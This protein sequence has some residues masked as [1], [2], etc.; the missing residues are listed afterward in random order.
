[1]AVSKALFQISTVLVHNFVDKHPLTPRKPLQMRVS[2]KCPFLRQLIFVTKSSTWKV[3][4]EI[5]KKFL[6]NSCGTFLWVTAP[7]RR[8][9]QQGF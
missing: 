9:E 2:T 8:A 7:F 3:N 4:E 6:D 1:V 5:E